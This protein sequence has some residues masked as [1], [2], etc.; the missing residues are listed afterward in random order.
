[1]IQF[2]EGEKLMFGKELASCLGVSPWYVAAMKRAGAP[3]QGRKSTLST[4]R[5][6]LS[7]NPEFSAKQAWRTK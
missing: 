7:K 2:T 5:A 3:F 4:L 1:M 6:W